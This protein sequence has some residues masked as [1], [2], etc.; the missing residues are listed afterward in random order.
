MSTST[1]L[2]IHGGA[3]TLLRSEMDAEKE[4]VYLQ[5]LETALTC[6]NTI[7]E[8]GGSALEAVEA[9]VSS[10]EDSPLFNAGKGSVFTAEGDHEM[11]A[12]VMEGRERMAGAVAGIRG[13]KNPIQLARQVMEQS[14]HVMLCGSGAEDFAKSI[15]M[16]FLPKDYFHD[17]FR[18]AQWRSVQGTDRV[19]LDHDLDP[20]RKYGTVG[21]V[22]KDVHGNLAAATSTGG[23][24]NKRYGRVGDSP[25]IGAGTYADNRTCA[26]SCTGSGEFF[27]REV[28]AFCVSALMEF[29]GLDLNEACKH[30]VHDR[31]KE[32]GGDGGLIA[33]DAEGAISMPFNTPGMYRASIRSGEEMYLGI[34]S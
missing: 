15:G 34:F 6:G 14:E 23:M 21:A 33:V 17:D 3:G 27:I 16:E 20:D 10:M 28:T 2:A 19:A 11:D 24:T 18:F 30:V 5:A 13:I 8:K 12:S 22:A 7:L 31:L 9:S 29:K 4:R 32:I 25:I 1:S 26:V